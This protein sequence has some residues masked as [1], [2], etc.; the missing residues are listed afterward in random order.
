MMNQ[1][2]TTPHSTCIEWNGH[3]KSAVQ[4]L[5]LFPNERNQ[6]FYCAPEAIKRLVLVFTR[7]NAKRDIVQHFCFLLIFLAMILITIPIYHFYVAYL[8]FFTF[9][10]NDS[11]SF[12]TRRPSGSGIM[13]SSLTNWTPNGDISEWNLTCVGN[14]S[15]WALWMTCIMAV[16]ALS[17]WILMPEM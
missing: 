12:Q 4:Y 14:N 15:G 13:D 6:F 3:C 17:P 9:W 10:Y 7:T 1:S 8:F 2:K 16:M 11:T 5:L